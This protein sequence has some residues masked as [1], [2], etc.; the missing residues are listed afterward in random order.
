MIIKILHEIEVQFLIYVGV[1]KCDRCI[2]SWSYSTDHISTER[3][4]I[5]SNI[6]M[7]LVLS[8]FGVLL[9]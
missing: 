4:T 6:L 7:P 8:H 5:F 9:H 1:S 2:S 3:C